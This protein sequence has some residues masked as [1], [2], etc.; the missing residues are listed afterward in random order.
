[1][2]SLHCSSDSLDVQRFLMSITV[3]T[4]RRIKG[5][6]HNVKSIACVFLFLLACAMSANGAESYT[7]EAMWKLKRLAAPAISPE[8]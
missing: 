8:P 5:K 1:M 3:L 6:P 2:R 7:A 4:T